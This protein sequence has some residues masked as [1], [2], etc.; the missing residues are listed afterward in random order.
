MQN[1]FKLQKN[2]QRKPFD[3]CCSVC[4][5]A[6]NCIADVVC[7]ELKQ[8]RHKMLQREQRPRSKQPLWTC[9]LRCSAEMTTRIS[10]KHLMLTRSWHSFAQ[11]VRFCT[12]WGWHSFAPVVRCMSTAVG[13]P[14][15]VGR[16]AS[17]DRQAVGC[18]GSKTVISYQLRLVKLL[19][20]SGSPTLPLNAGEVSKGS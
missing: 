14:T 7:N 4:S 11:A 10:R 19:V 16:H 20:R 3:H 18:A 6:S 5:T 15:K 9:S 8:W 17:L 13:A 12:N 1:R 2:K